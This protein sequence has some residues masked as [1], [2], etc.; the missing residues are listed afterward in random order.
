MVQSLYT[1]LTD[2]DLTSVNAVLTSISEQAHEIVVEGAKDAELIETRTAYMRYVGQGH[3]IRVPIPTRAL[4][5]AD[6]DK[7]KSTYNT[8]Y[9]QL[10]G[11]TIP[12]RVIEILSWSVVVS[13][14]VKAPVELS[15][16]SETSNANSSGE[17]AVFVPAQTGFETMATFLAT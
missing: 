11:R 8:C 17:R 10:Y 1:T 12:E 5:E 7:I 13:T 2:F 15:E 4:T 3:E 9:R 14:I 6:T 16:A